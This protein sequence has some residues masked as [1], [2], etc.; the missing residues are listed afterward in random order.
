MTSI[1]LVD[2]DLAAATALADDLAHSARGPF[3]EDRRLDVKALA[4]FSAARALLQFR[5]PALLVTALQLGKYNGLHLV[6]IVAAAGRATRSVVYTDTVDAI[7]AREVR[8]AG[9]FYEIR[10]RL[11]VAIPGYVSAMLPAQDRRDSL[12]FD[13]RHLPR[14]GRRAADLRPT[15]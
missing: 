7:L 13:R 11:E 4:D 2:P 14:G 1:L 15:L 10:S 8:A 12:H 6:H 9:A 5:P 3:A